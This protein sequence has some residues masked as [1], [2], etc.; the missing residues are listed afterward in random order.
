MDDQPAAPPAL[1]PSPIR[2]LLG[3]RLVEQRV[4]HVCIAY[5]QSPEHANF[6]G[7]LHGGILMTLLDEAAGIAGSLTE[8]GEIRKSV[9][10]D[11]SVHFTGQ[12]SGGEIRATGEVVRAGRN[13]YF[14]RS[15]VRDAAGQLLAF[16]ASTHRWRSAKATDEAR[17]GDQASSGSTSST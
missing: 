5:D 2:R 16:G 7:I 9:T 13:L 17:P 6:S 8:A 1:P 3:I 10:V 12:A 4:G 14:A 15:E 11:M